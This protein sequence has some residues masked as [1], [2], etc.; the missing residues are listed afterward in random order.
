M[1]MQ[2]KTS[3]EDRD[4]GSG[5]EGQRGGRGDMSMWKNPYRGL[6]PRPVRFCDGEYWY[7]N[8]YCALF[9]SNGL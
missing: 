7:S 8:G 9:A 5:A 2:G 3:T 4:G 1:Q 6:L